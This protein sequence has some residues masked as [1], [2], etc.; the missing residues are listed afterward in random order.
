MRDRYKTLPDA[1]DAA[2][3]LLVEKKSRFIA[4]GGSACSEKEA[5]DI[6][7]AVREK[8]PDVSHHVYAYRIGPLEKCSDG[9][10]PSGTAGLPVL[11]A[12][13]KAGLEYCMLVVTRWF[14]GILLGAGGLVRAY[15]AAAR[16]FA[17]AN[18]VTKARRLIFD[19]TAG[20]H[21]AN[22]LQSVIQKEGI[23]CESVK[24]MENVVFRLLTA[25]ENAEALKLTV[26][27]ATNGEAGV[28]CA[29][30]KYVL[31]TGAL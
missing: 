18:T 15:G 7:R 5:M 29:G 22:A 14:G 10:E 6:L 8:Y 28:L 27:N 19:V 21:A 20:Y 31:E 24:Y 2:E 16:G 11:G 3:Y 17:V 13:Q 23:A 9:G 26:Q 4:S 30:E 12:L 25:P 1:G